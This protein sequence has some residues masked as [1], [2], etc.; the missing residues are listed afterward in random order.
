MLLADPHFF[1][2]AVHPFDRAALI[3]QILKNHRVPS[4]VV[5]K[6][7][8]QIIQEAKNAKLDKERLG[9]WPL[10]VYF[11]TYSTNAKITEKDLVD[12][13]AVLRDFYLGMDINSYSSSDAKKLLSYIYADNP[14]APQWL[15]MLLQTL[16]SKS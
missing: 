11:V 2:L 9:L 7:F 12:L 14:Q 15:R 8:R 5:T 16:I 1:D 4:S 6:V 3:K 10:F 13:V